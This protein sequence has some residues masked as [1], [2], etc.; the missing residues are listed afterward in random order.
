MTEELIMELILLI[1]TLAILAGGYSIRRLNDLIKS[2]SKSYG[3]EVGK[4]DANTKKL[5]E[6]QRQLAQSVQISESIKTDIQHGAWRS[7]EL[8]LL[9]REK[10]EQYLLNYYEAIENLTRQ[11]KEVLFYDETPYDKSCH[12]RLSMIQRLYLPELDVEHACYLQVYANFSGW[13][14][15]GMRELHGKRKPEN[16]KPVIS[17]EHMERYS[18]LLSE[19]TQA[20]LLI[21][22]KAKEI[23]REINIA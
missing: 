21:E 23:G 3:A 14:V 8:E 7:R 11:M 20:T 17:S 6:I 12:A 13:L 15:A 1:L 19:A 16:M 22:A 18:E 2:Y 5:D 10:L 4:I 9:K